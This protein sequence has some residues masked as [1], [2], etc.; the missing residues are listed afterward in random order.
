[1]KTRFKVFFV[2]LAVLLAFAVPITAATTIIE[3]N[4]VNI[5]I[6]GSPVAAINE[7]L[8]GTST[9]YSILYDDTV[10][11][12]I[13]QIGDLLEL[14]VDWD[15][16]ARTVSV[17][18]GEIKETTTPLGK[19]DPAN[20]TAAKDGTLQVIFF[21]VGQAD[22]ILVRTGGSVMLIDAGNTGQDKLIL[23]YLAEHEINSLDYLVATHPHADHIGAMTSVVKAMGH[24]GEIIMPDVTHTTK[25]YENLLIAIEEKDIELTI[26]EVG[27]EFT[28]G[29]AKIQVLAP[30]DADPSDLNECSVVLRVE[31]GDTVFLFTGDA[32]TK[33]ENAQLAGGLTLKADVLKVGH[34]GSRTSS[35]QKYLDAV[36]P[37]YAVISCGTGNSY[38][39]PH[40]EAM[41]RLR[42]T[43]A[44]I[45][46]TD[47]NGT[48][49]FETDG[50]D[51]FVSVESE[52]VAQQIVLSYIGNKNSKIFHLPSCRS[53]PLE[54]NAVAFDTKTAALDAGYSPCGACKP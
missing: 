43:G 2:V 51:I 52:P 1:M 20:L 54:Q 19:L 31:F 48:I 8:P 18:G 47:E 15:S 42:G 53:L 7:N 13:R 35:S 9:P 16:D 27:G 23:G 6:N 22:C 17:S 34:H 36:A 12:P 30:L 44:V 28:L 24:I 38:G 32:G 11:L 40:S 37:R 26:A 21:D 33:S 3:T 14:E 41:T 50:K 4:S 29:A 39:H 46:R 45:Y 10:Y 5:I 49:V 25:T